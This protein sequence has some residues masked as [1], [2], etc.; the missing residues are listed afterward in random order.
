MQLRPRR[1]INSNKHQQQSSIHSRRRNRDLFSN[2]GKQ[3][4]EKN[5]DE[6]KQAIPMVA[7]Y[8]LRMH[9]DSKETV[10]LWI[11]FNEEPPSS[12]F[13]VDVTSALSKREASLNESQQQQQ[14]QQQT[15][16][17]NRYRT[18]KNKRD[19]HF[20]LILPYPSLL[21]PNSKTFQ[22][23]ERFISERP[24]INSFSSVFYS[25]H[26]I[27]N[28]LPDSQGSQYIRP[29]PELSNMYFYPPSDSTIN[30]TEE[31]DES[32]KQQEWFGP[33]RR[34][35]FPITKKD[36]ND[37]T[38]ILKK[39]HPTIPWFPP[40][41]PWSSSHTSTPT[42]PG[43]KT[44]HHP[45]IQNQE[46]KDENWIRI[47]HHTVLGIHTGFQEHVQVDLLK[48]SKADF[49]KSVSSDHQLPLNLQGMW[50]LGTRLGVSKA[51]EFLAM[52][53]ERVLGEDGAGGD[54]I[55]RKQVGKMNDTIGEGTGGTEVKEEESVCFVRELF[56]FDVSG[57]FGS[58]VLEFAEWEGWVKIMKAQLRPGVFK[59][60]FV[61][62]D[63]DGEKRKE[64]DG[65]YWLNLARQL[66]GCKIL[67]ADSET[68]EHA[69]VAFQW[70]RVRYRSASEFPLPEYDSTVIEITYP[71]SASLPM[72]VKENIEKR[73]QKRR[74]WVMNVCFALK[75]RH[76]RLD[77]DVLWV[78]TQMKGEFGAKVDIY[79]PPTLTRLKRLSVNQRKGQTHGTLVKYTIP[80]APIMQILSIAAPHMVPF[81][82][83][84]N[85]HTTPPPPTG[86]M[87]SPKT[88]FLLFMPW[89]QLNNQFIA[90]KSVCAVAAILNRTLVL[91][92]V[93]FRSHSPKKIYQQHQQQQQI[94]R[95][96]GGD[97]TKD[98]EWDFNFRIREYAWKTFD[99]YFLNPTTSSLSS[100]IG[101]DDLRLFASAS[102]PSML[103]TGHSK[104]NL[105]CE[106][107]SFETYRGLLPNG[108]DT[109]ILPKPILNR[110]AKAT[111]REQL[112]EYY[113][114]VLGLRTRRERVQ[115]GKDG[116]ESEVGGEE[117]EE[118][119]RWMHLNKGEVLKFLAGEGDRK[120]GV[121]AG[122]KEEKGENYVDVKESDGVM[123]SLKHFK[124]D[125]DHLLLGASFWLYGFGKVQ[126]YPLTEFVSYINDVGHNGFDA[127]EETAGK[128]ENSTENGTQK[129]SISD[130]S[131]RTDEDMESDTTNSENDR[132]R[133]N[134]KSSNNTVSSKSVTIS[135]FD[136]NMYISATLGIQLNHK[137]QDIVHASYEAL[138]SRSYSLASTPLPSYLQTQNQNAN[139]PVV[140]R[141]KR[142]PYII[143]IHLRR[144][145]YWNKCKR[146]PSK[147]LKAH[148][149]PSASKIIAYIQRTFKRF[150]LSQQRWVRGE[151][152]NTSVSSASH[153]AGAGANM[154][155]EDEGVNANKGI[156]QGVIYIATN[157]ESKAEIR[158]S[159]LEPLR[160]RGYHVL[161]YEDVVGPT[162]DRLGL[163]WNQLVK[164]RWGSGG[165][166]GGGDSGGGGDDDDIDDAEYEGATQRDEDR[167]SD[168]DGLS[169]DPVETS[170][171]E[172]ELCA[173]MDYFIGNFYSSFSRTII[174][175]RELADL[176]FSTF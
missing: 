47:P 10:P 160:I 66:K 113:G 44:T 61:E 83:S 152:F 30:P 20:T 56:G 27:L 21:T 108:P 13:T 118:E 45:Q 2:W 4:P 98:K 138:L 54:G 91:P 140:D 157:P 173:K 26:S 101:D 75:L 85:I 142:I 158:Q 136:R 122:N 41:P 124:K 42:P 52:R 147:S 167:D 127:R 150:L 65:G 36:S 62:I 64:D 22:T 176:P 50:N 161:F 89:E 92:H 134:A 117:A 43:T 111:D 103:V 59:E 48:P 32:E 164:T 74:N 137:L 80:M 97:R 146:I 3:T 104:P 29:T 153:F 8:P 40:L 112:E 105:P 156:Y 100:F 93:G 141:S 145:D 69:L 14:Q 38:S 71:S 151:N 120:D 126:P 46:K 18:Q 33:P 72:R 149:Y 81:P 73:H 88:K 99:S 110:M 96:N 107:I 11:H 95:F 9:L 148:C 135:E 132:V 6:K 55:E 174:E 87:Q 12:L 49:L 23:T 19:K 53:M 76:A 133:N 115:V 175:K 144:G 131:D 168:D 121:G 35:P 109:T 143:S 155:V 37:T 123:T 5:R 154:D 166:N 82:K 130:E 77:V 125:D 114:G 58:G 15:T 172:M 7:S 67:I 90:F 159:L 139:M 16:H 24:T 84:A 78:S 68:L 116:G 128:A 70:A 169:L 106:T 165:G 31:T 129:Y 86:S 162:L 94:R 163:E 28:T 39:Q 51:V 17:E 171:V 79:N 102:P 25:F 170:L 63:K 60:V 34:P 119:V 57:R 1:N